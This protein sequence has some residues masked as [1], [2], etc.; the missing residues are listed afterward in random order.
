[1]VVAMT[2]EA[3][4]VAF[5]LL[6]EELNKAEPTTGLVLFAFPLHTTGECAYLHNVTTEDVVKLLEQELAA[7]RKDLEDESSNRG[8]SH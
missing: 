4:H 5:N 8:P 3:L 1:M 7:F 6:N 2:D